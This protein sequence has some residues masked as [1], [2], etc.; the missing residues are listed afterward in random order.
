M[1]YVGEVGHGVET[2]LRAHGGASGGGGSNS[3]RLVGLLFLMRVDAAMKRSLEI[4]IQTVCRPEQVDSF[5]R[6]T[7]KTVR[8]QYD[9]CLQAAGAWL[10]EPASRPL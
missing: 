4:Q 7:E 9:A 2:R 3:V 10:V 1:E 6:S 5:A 8:R